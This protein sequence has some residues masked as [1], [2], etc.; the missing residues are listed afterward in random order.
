M[1]MDMVVDVCLICMPY[2]YAIE[3]VMDMDVDSKIGMNVE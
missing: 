2:M 1:G 3:M